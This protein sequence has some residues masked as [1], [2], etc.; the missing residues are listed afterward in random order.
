MNDRYDATI[1]DLQE[2]RIAIEI[3]ARWTAIQRQ[4]I[5]EALLWRTK[6]DQIFEHYIGLENGQ[7]A[8][9]GVGKSGERCYLIA[10][11]SDDALWTKLS[12]A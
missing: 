3:P 6:L 10:E 1:W 11:R 9:T 5:D 2:S 12:A 7:Y 8:V 4:E